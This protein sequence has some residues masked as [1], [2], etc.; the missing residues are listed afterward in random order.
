MKKQ[1]RIPSVK[2]L[3][4]E[5]QK[6]EKKMEKNKAMYQRLDEIVIKLVGK[7]LSKEKYQVVDNFEEKNCVFRPAGVRRYELKKIKPQEPDKK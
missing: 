4:L 2:E 3:L 6:I 1:V 5:F 7:D